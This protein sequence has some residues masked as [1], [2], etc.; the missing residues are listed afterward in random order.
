[1]KKKTSEQIGCGY[2]R[3]EKSCKDYEPKKNKAK[4]C[5]NFVHH[6]LKEVIGSNAFFKDKNDSVVFV[7]NDIS[8]K[9][10][11]L[12]K[13]RVVCLE[14]KGNKENLNKALAFLEAN[15]I[16]YTSATEKVWMEAL[17]MAAGFEVE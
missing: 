16:D 9:P 11:P 15:D 8:I 12:D 3:H 4:D 6:E 10:T 14:T 5:L 1:M 13:V 17:K 2:C 7:P